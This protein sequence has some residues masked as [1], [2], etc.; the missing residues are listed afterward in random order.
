MSSDP[1]HHTRDPLPEELRIATFEANDEG[2]LICGAPL[3]YTA[4]EVSA[5]NCSSQTDQGGFKLQFEWSHGLADYLGGPPIFDNG[6][7]CCGRKL[8]ILCH[9][10]LLSH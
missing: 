2:C 7:K 6:Y 9:I 1:S 4:E 8:M 10:T 3:M 5:W